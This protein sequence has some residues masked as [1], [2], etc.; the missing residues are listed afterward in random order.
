MELNFLAVGE[1]RAASRSASWR[2][3]STLPEV[4][5]ERL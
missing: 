2:A 5:M 3:K 4:A 1:L